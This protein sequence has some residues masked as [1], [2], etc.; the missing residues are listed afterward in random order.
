VPAGLPACLQLLARPLASHLPARLPACP[1]ARLPACL[2]QYQSELAGQEQG[3]RMPAS[4]R[5]PK[6]PSSLY[7]SA[8]RDGEAVKAIAAFRDMIEKAV[9]FIESQAST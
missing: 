8:C 1:P 2:P 9:G 6:L 3:L 7:S 5:P 4:V